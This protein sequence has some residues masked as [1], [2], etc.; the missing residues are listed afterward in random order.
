M[1]LS[2]ISNH[3]KII[4]IGASLV[5]MHHSYKFNYSSRLLVVAALLW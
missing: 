2:K 3:T 4:F 1:A 5:T